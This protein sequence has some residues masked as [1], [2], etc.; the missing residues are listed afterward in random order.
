MNTWIV[1][2]VPVAHLITKPVFK[3]DSSLQRRGEKVFFLKGRIMAGQADL[4]K[5]TQGLTDFKWVTKDGLKEILP[6]EY[7]HGVRNMMADR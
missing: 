7:Y 1:G 3:E 2:R 5:N 4:S 6:E